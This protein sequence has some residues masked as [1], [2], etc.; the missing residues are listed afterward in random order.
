MGLKHCHNF[1]DFRALARSRLPGPIFDYIDG[2]ADD[3]IT[4]G[5]NS[6]S[7]DDCDLVP[8]VL[9]GVETVDMSVTV[10]GQK[11]AMPIYCSPTALQRLFHHEGEHAVAA[12]ANKFGTMFGVSSMGTVSLKELREKYSTPQFY[13]FY[14][15]KDRGLNKAMLE[16]AKASGVDVMMLTVDTITAGNRERDLRTGFS[17]PLKLT[18]AG[19]YQF[20]IKPRWAIN[21][22]THAKFSLPQIEDFVDMTGGAL[23][24]SQY[25]NEMLDPSMDWDDVAEMVKLWDGQFCLKGI[26]SVEDA[27]RAV[28][29]GCSGIVISNH[30][31]RQLDG[32][33]SP[34]DQLAE[35]VNAVGDKIDVVM[36]SGIQRGSHVLKALSLGAK[37]V[38]G[39][40][41]YLYALAAAGQPG[42]ERALDLMRIEIERDMRLMGVKSLSELS[43]N[44][45]RFR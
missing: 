20:A 39:G 6:A 29:I 14:F 43:S 16:A 22:L 41:F 38:G 9:R 3:E 8:N 2:A 35:I 4:H 23:S 42:V 19:A 12:A 25:L 26:M 18:L 27:K 44:N 37:A 13:Q 7:F 45:L 5:R 10:M 11:L 40:R 31:G 36:D 15:H 30:G 24:V 21:Y 1:H 34:F 28:D 32:S 17:M 33:R